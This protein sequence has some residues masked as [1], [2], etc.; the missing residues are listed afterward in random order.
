MHRRLARRDEER[1]Q[2]Q[3]QH[4][5]RRR[6]EGH[7]PAGRRVQPEHLARVTLRD[8][9]RQEG[10]RRRLRRADEQ[11]HGDPED[12]EHH[13]PPV[14]EQEDARPQPHQ[15]AQRDQDH[16]FRPGPVVQVPEDDGREPRDHVGHHTEDD[17]LAGAEPEHQFRQHRTVGEH[18]RQAV[19]EQRGGQQEPGRVRGDAVDAD[20]GTYEVAV[21]P[22]RRLAR[23]RGGHGPVLDGHEQRNGEQHRPG[24]AQK[25]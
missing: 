19:A 20:H 1:S 5:Q 15:R 14:V 22:Q 17:H 11:G 25:H 3:G 2:P 18:P 10:P 9:T 21:G 13:R 4:P 7:R 24:P 23:R 16:P 6:Q 12:P 8:Q